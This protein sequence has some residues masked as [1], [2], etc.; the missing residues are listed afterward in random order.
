MKNKRLLLFFLVAIWA[1]AVWKPTYSQTLDVSIQNVG[2]NTMQIV[3]TAT[4][5]GFTGPCA[6]WGAMNISIRIPKSAT[7]VMPP[8]VS[9]FPM[10][11]SVVTSEST[12]FTGVSMRDAFTH[13]LE[14][15]IFDKTSFGFSDDGNWYIQLESSDGGCQAIS[16]GGSVVI[17]QFDLPDGWSCAG[18][19]EILTTD[20]PDIPVSTTSFIDNVC[21]ED[22]LNVVTNN[23]PLPIELLTF[24][25]RANKCDL[26]LY[27]ETATERNLGYFQIEASKDG[28]AFATAAQQKPA[29][30][31]SSTLRTYRYAVPT[32]L[33]NQYFRLKAVD[34]DGH[35]EYSPIVFAKAPC[36]DK[37]YEINLY[38]NPNYT[39]ELTVEVNSPEAIP[40]SKLL[41]TDVF[42]KQV[43]LQTVNIQVGINK[44]PINTEQLPSG[45][46]FVKIVGIDPLQEPLKFV[47]SNF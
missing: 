27:W 7:S 32:D 18:C 36:K 35:F 33:H 41:V 10:A 16:T 39:S 22:V 43:L 14:I 3:G 28:R 24:E 29:S 42:G 47:R 15:S 45:T 46:Y 23:A 30:P 19:V 8:I 34:L 1:V 5:P 20:V 13:T 21:Y 38:P 44:L 4:A 40:N 26:S 17:Y 37:R 2:D 11:S 25:T 31:N 12:T 6:C 9:E